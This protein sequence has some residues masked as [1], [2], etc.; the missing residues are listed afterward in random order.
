VYSPAVLPHPNR[1][2]DIFLII[3]LLII[4]VYGRINPR[5]ILSNSII[6]LLLF[7]FYH[8][9]SQLIV[10]STEGYFSLS[11]SKRIFLML[12]IFLSYLLGS[13]AGLYLS[14]S[15]AKRL[16]IVIATILGGVLLF[17][18][19][20]YYNILGVD[21]LSRLYSSGGSQRSGLIEKLIHST[22][23]A[24]AVGTFGNPNYFGLILVFS[25]LVFTSFYIGKPVRSNLLIATVAIVVVTFAIILTGSRTALIISIILTFIFYASLLFF[26][27]GTNVSYLPKT[28]TV[29]CTAAALYFLLSN[30]NRVGLG[31][32]TQA[33]ILDISISSSYN[34]RLPL[35]SSNL[36]I[37]SDNWA[38]WLFGVG[39]LKISREIYYLPTFTDSQYTTLL[40]TYGIFG[41]TTFIALVLCNIYISVK[42]FRKKVNPIVAT[43]GYISGLLSFSLLFM[44][45][46]TDVVYEIRIISL[47]MLLC[48]FTY[49]LY[50]KYR[51]HQVY[52]Y[53]K[54]SM[55]EAI[56]SYYK[57]NLSPKRRNLDLH[58]KS[59]RKSSSL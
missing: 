1:L 8:I 9:A 38:K 39:P 41:L 44:M 34:T 4:L 18:I 19:M 20:Q 10:I 42:L 29:L 48:G 23:S 35:W 57:R 31:S 5:N 37:L 3:P 15:Q 25:Q 43:Y 58:E 51:Y 11:D 33:R 21:K 55:G 46:T 27:K 49:G 53:P 32:T 28:V 36:E 50:K 26:Y 54:N 45:I 6:W 22:D 52:K 7:I 13:Y 12:K 47:F 2:E 17:G 59:S 56:E 30:I 14:T 24:R 40:R 16:L